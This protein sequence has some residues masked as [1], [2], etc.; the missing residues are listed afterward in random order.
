MG[1][2]LHTHMKCIPVLGH[3]AA[4]LG[5]A[6]ERFLMDLTFWKCD[7]IVSVTVPRLPTSQI[8]N[9]GFLHRIMSRYVLR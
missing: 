6:I 4:R 8:S 9:I 2:G 3:S 7:V 1:G 5:S